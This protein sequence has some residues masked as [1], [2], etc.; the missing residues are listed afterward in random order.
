[1]TGLA[2]RIPTVFAPEQL[3]PVFALMT[4]PMVDAL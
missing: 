3:A 1:M 2:Q 4:V